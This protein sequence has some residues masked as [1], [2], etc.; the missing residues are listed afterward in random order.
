MNKPSNMAKLALV[1]KKV[2]GNL[3]FTIKKPIRGRVVEIK[4]GKF[5]FPFPDR[6]KKHYEYEP[7]EKEDKSCKVMF[8]IPF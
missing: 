2:G 8:K 1:R 7:T 6:K 5:K 3:S 4:V